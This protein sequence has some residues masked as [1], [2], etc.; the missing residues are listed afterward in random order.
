MIQSNEALHRFRE[1]LNKKYAPGTCKYNSIGDVMDPQS[2]L[3]IGHVAEDGSVHPVNS[4]KNDFT[5]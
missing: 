2:H 1:N 3:V 4:P 5:L